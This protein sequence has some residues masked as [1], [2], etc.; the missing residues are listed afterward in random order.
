MYAQPNTFKQLV[1][2]LTQV[3][4]SKEKARLLVYVELTLFLAEQLGLECEPLTVGWVLLSHT[5]LYHPQL[6]RLTPV[7]RRMRANAAIIVPLSSR[8]AWESALAQY[9]KDDEAL[10]HLRLYV[11]APTRLD[12]QMICI[13]RQSP[14]PNA[15]RIEYYE[16]ILTEQLPFE[17]RNRRYTEAEKTYK[18]LIKA[19]DGEAHV[20][21]VTITAQMQQLADQDAAWFDTKPARVALNI[22]MSDLLPTA[23]FLDDYERRTGGRVHWEHD[24]YQ[25]RFRRI[26]HT[27]SGM[28]LDEENAH[29]LILDGAIHLPGT[30][31]AGKTTL[32]KLVIAHC[33]RLGWD[34]RI[35]LV[36]GDTNSAIEIAHQVNSWFCES[37]EDEAVVAVPLLG[38]SQ[39]EVNLGRLLASRQYRKTL[40]ERQPHWGERWLMPI[41]PLASRI[42]WEGAADVQLLAGSEPCQGLIA[43]SGKGRGKRHLCPLFTICPSKQMYRDLPRAR[44][45]VTTPGALAQAK[46]PLHLDDRIHT[47]GDLVYE[48]SDLVILDEVETIVDWYD[49]TFAR[50]EELTNGKNGLL[51]RLDTQISAYLMTNRVQ[52]SFEHRWLMTV[53]E[54]VK[55]LNGVLTALANPRQERIAKNWVKRGY[56]APNQLAY[57]LARRLAGLKEWDAPDTLP[58]KRHENDVLTQKTFEPFDELLNYPPDPLRPRANMQRST[59]AAELTQIMQAMNN[60]ADD[61]SDADLFEQCRD[62]ILRWHPDIEEKLAKLRDQLL[63]SDDFDREYA[64]KQ[65]DRSSREL[66][67]RLQFTLLVALLDRHL[68][69]VIHEWYHKPESLEAQQPFSHIPRGARC[70]LPLPLTGQQYGFVTHTGSIKYNRDAANRLGLFSYTSIGRSYLLNFHCLRQDFDGESGPHVLALSGTSYLPD[71]TAF[72]VSIPPAGILLPS[73]QTEQAIKD[74][75]FIWRPFTNESDKPIKISG[76]GNKEEQLR[77]LVRAMLADGGVPGGMFGRELEWLETQGQAHPDQWKDRARILLL[78]NSYSQSKAVAI[79]LREGWRAADNIFDLKQAKG[80]GRDED[81]QVESLHGNQLQRMDIEQ[82]ATHKN[83]R[84]LVAPMQSIGRG[85]NIL[86]DQPEPKAAFGAVFFLTRPMNTPNDREAIAQELNRYALA[87][88]EDASFVAWNEDTLYQRALKAR[89]SAV[90]LTRAI[91]RRRRYKELIDDAELRVYPRRDLAATTA[92]RIVQAVGR[93]LRGGVPFRAY[94]IDAA[95]SPELAATGDIDRI[96]SEETSLLTALIN[97]MDE[98]SLNDLIGQYLYGDLSGALTATENRDSN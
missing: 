15:E 73:H 31:S 63:Q 22:S 7:Q 89:E 66:A 77:Q 26:N 74:S 71:S 10:A 59:K 5:P 9:S 90:K 4:G 88:A 2:N 82:F 86:N 18:V 62:W 37:P 19:A 64:T 8:Y 43:E 80:S 52:P 46:I 42:K 97:I 85:F 81:Y 48:Q 45:W 57:R 39:G 34:V 30:V 61:V 6:D 38:V 72:H 91:E 54:A 3:I 51:D 29:P 68:H 40:K 24:L 70:I 58:M 28:S 95:W 1:R 25:I 16:R 76:A 20:G 69:V 93:L 17:K 12:N 50:H 84:I 83:G 92:G 56:F 78:T 96:E 21:W 75:R 65:Q 94:F 87:W 27:E 11:I 98:Y 33:I 53:R 14:S 36:V 23:Q 67:A 60:L 49:R 44:L 35:T 41:C 13:C 79:A 55:A 47:F 32:A